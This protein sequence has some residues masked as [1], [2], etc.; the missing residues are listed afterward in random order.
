MIQLHGQGVGRRQGIYAGR[1]RTGR[2][3]RAAY[4]NMEL[5]E[6]RMLMSVV[7]TNDYDV[8]SGNANYAGSLRSA[9]NEVNSLGSGTI[10]FASTLTGPTGN[11]ITL[12]QGELELE[13]TEAYIDGPGITINGDSRPPDLWCN[14]LF[15]GL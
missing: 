12:T 14:W 11:T 4:G 13:H 6:P 1:R 10:T 8:A 2:L 7:V 3:A 5:L 9:V 15:I